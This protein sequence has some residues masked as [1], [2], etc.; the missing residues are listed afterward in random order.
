ML[1]QRRRAG[2]RLS[3]FIAVRQS[4]RLHL[5]TDG[6]IYT[7]DGTLAAVGLKAIELPHCLAAFT[8][9][10][11]LQPGLT[12]A[13]AFAQFD[14]FDDVIRHAPRVLSEVRTH[15][16]RYGVTGW[17]C[18]LV[19]MSEKRDP[20]IHY[21]PP[22]APLRLIEDDYWA[23]GPMPSVATMREV[24]LVPPVSM[25]DFDPVRH[26]IPAME[27]FRRTPAILDSQTPSAFGHGVGGFVAHT[28]ITRERVTTTVIHEWGDALGQRIIAPC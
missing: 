28:E 7:P 8:V 17:E 26:G 9:R 20:E 10:G 15:W 5:L 3:A 1:R 16:H 11:V 18:L 22:G 19:G 4:D 13:V 14:R 12:L 6:A 23:G 25:A 24:G 2:I 27:A 21:C